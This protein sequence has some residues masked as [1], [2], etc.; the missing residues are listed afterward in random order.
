MTAKQLKTLHFSV[1][2]KV[3]AKYTGQLLL[4]LAVLYSVPLLFSLATGEFVSSWPYVA[5]IVISGA[6]GYFLQRI[7]ATAELQNNETLVISALIFISASLL[8]AL[9][10]YHQDLS[11]IDALFEA[12]SGVTTTGLSTLPSVESMPMTFQFS[13]AWLQWIGGLGIVVLSVAIILPQSKATL[14]LFRENWEKEG[15]VSGTRAYARIILEVYLCMTLTGII[16]LISMGVNWFDAIS[17]ILAAVSTGG[18]S[19]YDNSLAGLSG[20]PVQAAVIF[21]SCLGAVP[22]FIYYSLFRGDWRKLAG[23]FEIKGLLLVA[24]L[25][26][27]ATISMLNTVDGLP[28]RQAIGDGTL[29]A[30][31]AQ[32]TTGFSTISIPKLSEASK[33]ITILFMFIGGNVGSTAG[34]IKILRLLIIFKMIRLLVARS[35]LPPSAVVQPRLAGRR[36]ESFEVERSFLLIFLFFIVIL[37]SLL[38]FLILGYPFLDSLFEIV[39]ATCTVGLSTGITSPSLPTLLKGILCLDM[40]MGRLEIVAFLILFYPPAWFGK[41]R[42]VRT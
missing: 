5:I 20:L 13:R 39:S 31:S 36:L 22:L 32:T 19:R 3:I 35:G 23:N 42:G 33:L 2:P 8:A 38:P 11:F 12:V 14:H 40:L 7:E 28:L 27:A 9:P 18:F 16:L 34:G 4:I 26:V 6:A 10:F 24:V 1:R 37:L 21:I 17:H 29:L 41:K 15:L 30:L 25:A